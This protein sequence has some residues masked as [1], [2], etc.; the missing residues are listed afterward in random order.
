MSEE[1]VAEGDSV[2]RAKDELGGNG[3]DADIAPSGS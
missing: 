3:E 1:S 2:K